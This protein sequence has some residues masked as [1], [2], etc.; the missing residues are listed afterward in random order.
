MNPA[1][2]GKEIMKSIVEIEINMPQQQVA[3]LFAD[4]GNNPKWMPDFE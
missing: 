1:L 2:K 4:P 3:E